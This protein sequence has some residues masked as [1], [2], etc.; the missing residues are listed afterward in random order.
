[1]HNEVGAERGERIRLMMVDDHPIVRE[2]MALFLNAQPDLD[3]CYQAGSAEEALALLEREQA[4]PALVIV[5][6]QLH[7]DSGLELIRT[8]RRRD[9]ALALLAMSLHEESVFAERALRAGARGYLMKQEATG[10]ILLAIRKV[11]AGEIYL[12]AAMHGRLTRGAGPPAAPADGPLAGLSE[13]EFEV[14]HLL[15]LG[16]GT[17]QI[18]EKLQRSIKTIE[19]HRASLKEKLKLASG[20]ELVRFALRWLDERPPD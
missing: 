7:R 3:L 11:L 12:S 10:N 6:I 8:L 15:A 20:A 13:R 17:R 1:M 18:S 5:D 4:R 2:G 16:F 19:A 14:L 9:P